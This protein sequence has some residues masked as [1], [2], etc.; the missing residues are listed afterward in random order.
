[1][2]RFDGKTALVTGGSR[3]IGLGIAQR[4]AAEGARV[5]I[6]GRDE[7]SLAEAAST[8]PKGQILTVSGK[9]Q[10]PAHRDQVLDQIANEF[11]QLDVLVNNAGTNPVYGPMTELELATA[12][13]VMEINLIGTLA[14][15][16]GAANHPK[17]GFSDGGAVVNV[18]SI[19]SEVPGEGIGIYGVS[20][21]AIN[22]LTKTLAAEMGPGVRVNA[23]AP[24]VVKTVFAAALYE[25]KEEEVASQ[26]PLRRLGQ[27][28]DIAGPVAF[29]ASD[30]ARWVTGQ[31]LDVD[32]GILAVGGARG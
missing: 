9:S 18:S 29:L 26:Y 17:L 30:D 16:Q 14:W 15:T 11:G 6:T 28:E 21:A 3:G 19:S 20:K 2:Q 1:M 23:V 5:C 8:F 27:P 32:G 24:G 4:L 25:G 13:K 7:N 31:V 12:S 22:H 10:D